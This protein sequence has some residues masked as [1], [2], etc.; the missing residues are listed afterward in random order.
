MYFEFFTLKNEQYQ[1]DPFSTVRNIIIMQE[2]EWI[3]VYWEARKE[4]FLL[5]RKWRNGKQ[6][7]KEK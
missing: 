7:H 1:L 6:V 2:Y 5:S 3:D 4:Y